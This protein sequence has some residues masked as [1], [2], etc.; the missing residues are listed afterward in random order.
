MSVEWSPALLVPTRY[1][2]FGF[3]PWGHLNGR[4][5][6]VCNRWSLLV[7]SNR[8]GAAVLNESTPAMVIGGILPLFGSDVV[9]GTQPSR[10]VMFLLPA[11]LA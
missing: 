7:A 11:R 9:I 4:G 3:P 10:R 6:G 1:R 5:R 8:F 2:G